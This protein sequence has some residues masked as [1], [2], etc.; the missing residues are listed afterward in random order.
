MKN[1]SAGLELKS[2]ASQLKPRS[3]VKEST[4]FEEFADKSREIERAQDVMKYGGSGSGKKFLYGA[5]SAL[6]GEEK[7]GRIAQKYGNRGEQEEAF[8]TLYG[9]QKQQAQS[10]SGATAAATQTNKN[11]SNMGKSISN[12]I[13]RI[14][15]S[16][17]SQAVKQILSEMPD[18][19]QIKEIVERIEKRISPRDVTIGKGENAQTYR[20][21]PLAPAGKQV[22]EVQESG[23]A[24]GIAS[25]EGGGRSDY[26][27][28]TSK[29]A[30]FANQDL[31]S[32]GTVQEQQRT[33]PQ[34]TQKIEKQ[35][36]GDIV[37]EIKEELIKSKLLLMMTPEDYQTK[38]A[39]QGG[40]AQ[41]QQAKEEKNVPKNFEEYLKLTQETEKAQDIM[42][43]G[44]SGSMRKF[45]YGARSA[46]FGDERAKQISRDKGNREEQEQAFQFLTGR[47]SE[48]TAPA[49]QTLSVQPQTQQS[50][51]ADVVARETQEMQ[52]AE[53]T[54][55]DRE[56]K[57]DTQKTLDDMLLKLEEISK[58]LDENSGGGLLGGIGGGGALRLLA[59]AARLAGPAL[60]VAA[61]GYAGYKVGE[62]INEQTGASEAIADVLTNDKSEEEVAAEDKKVN[63]S[64][65]DKLNMKLKGTGYTALGA[66]KYRGPEGKVYSKPELP[67][68]IIQ[69]L[70]GPGAQVQQSVTPTPPPV[71][72]PPQVVP[73]EIPTQQV[74]QLSQENDS[75]RSERTQPQVVVAPLPQPTI[76]APPVDNTPAKQETVMIQVRNVEPTIST[77]VASIFDHPVTHPGI[78][79]M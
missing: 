27:R 3:A 25:K 12:K 6:L 30:F 68:Q 8:Q 77:Y 35:K 32:R 26:E 33:N 54:E 67:P 59:S 46:I 78:Y 34:T 16:E 62:F 55:F 20:F 2:V 11:I 42:R 31:I 40:V 38:V 52:Q 64:A 24:G 41:Q 76:T 13:E 44:G 72:P 28:V 49:V 73:R 51:P 45:M 70:D 10:A 17:V 37:K 39:G 48:E 65:I 43:F 5:T 21:D 22:T 74:G 23:L 75:L 60:G 63:S 15:K 50:A 4:T 66:G 56:Y 69:K 19:S 58:K 29:A 36:A 1:T 9:N 7:A 79:K 71:I 57:Q 47:R 61:A 18:V 53:S 14:V